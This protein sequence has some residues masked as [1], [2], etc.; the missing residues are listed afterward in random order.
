MSNVEKSKQYITAAYCLQRKYQNVNHNNKSI[1][2]KKRYNPSTEAIKNIYYCV[3]IVFN[4]LF[5]KTVV[6]KGKKN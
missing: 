3:W 2:D 5:D 1:A 4:L 6:E